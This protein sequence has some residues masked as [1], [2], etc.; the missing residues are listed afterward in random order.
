[1]HPPLPIAI[2]I[3]SSIIASLVQAS[4]EMSLLTY[5]RPHRL[6]NFQSCHASV[7]HGRLTHCDRR[8]LPLDVG[9]VLKFSR[10][11]LEQANG[12]D[13]RRVAQL[14]RGSND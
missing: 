4:S 13:D 11:D 2:A 9:V 5:R 10:R 6:R 8:R 14:R 3:A 1:M 12:A 7:H